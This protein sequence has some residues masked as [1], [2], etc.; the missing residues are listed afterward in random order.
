MQ[1][2]ILSTDAQQLLGQILARYG[3]LEAFRDYLNAC[4]DA[5]TLRLPSVWLPPAAPA[6]RHRRTE[7]I[8]RTSAD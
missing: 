5:P 2:R 4:L 3:T 6:G 7:P 8:T 1:Q